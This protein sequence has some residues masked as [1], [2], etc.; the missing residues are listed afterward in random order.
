AEIPAAAWTQPWVVDRRLVGSGAAALKYL[1]PYIFRVALS[2]N[3]I[4]QLADDQVTFRYIDSL[5]EM[6][7]GRCPQCGQVMPARPLAP[8]RSRGPP[9]ALRTSHRQIS[10]CSVCWVHLPMCLWLA[11]PLQ[12]GSGAPQALEPSPRCGSMGAGTVGGT[13]W[14]DKCVV[15]Q[16][17]NV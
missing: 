9:A 14:R 4:V 12:Q 17:V 5:P 6:A 1:A 16:Y 3:R 11:L 13:R 7:V 15:W 10:F 2:N 8:L